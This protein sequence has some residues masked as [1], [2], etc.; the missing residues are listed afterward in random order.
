[1]E[2]LI[3]RALPEEKRDDEALTARC[4]TQWREEYAKRWIKHTRPYEGIPD[5]LH[6]L[7]NRGL[8][9]GV[10]SN[11]PHEPT[12]EIISRLLPGP[13]FVEVRGAMP[14][15]PKKPDPTTAS[16]MAGRLGVSPERILYL[17]D[18][19]VDMKTAVGAGL[20]PVGALWGFR[21]ARELIETGA[22]SLFP[23]PGDLL[24]WVTGA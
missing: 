21:E 14:D 6:A 9:L 11:K 10:L 2:T 15:F 4:I 13:H 23:R 7:R 22:R 8:A 5:L 12:V 17:G 24:P 1:M 18:T 16:A 19:A 20:Y 3:L